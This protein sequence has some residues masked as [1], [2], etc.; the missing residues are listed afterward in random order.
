LDYLG[1]APVRGASY[2]GSGET[3]AVRLTVHDADMQQGQQQA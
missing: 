2:G 3:L 1:A